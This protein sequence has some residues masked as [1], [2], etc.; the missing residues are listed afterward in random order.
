MLSQNRWS[1]LRGGTLINCAL[2]DFQS[3]RWIIVRRNQRRPGLRANFHQVWSDA[4]QNCIEA[5]NGPFGEG[6][7]L[8]CVAQ[9]MQPAG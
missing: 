1:L 5:L 6:Q 4:G 9:T 8:S 3:Q 2:Q 7:T